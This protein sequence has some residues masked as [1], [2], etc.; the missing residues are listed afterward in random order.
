MNSILKN[1]TIILSIRAFKHYSRSGFTNKNLVKATVDSLDRMG[2]HWI[3]LIDTKNS[4]QK[5][6]IPYL[7]QE[8]CEEFDNL[9]STEKRELDLATHTGF[10]GGRFILDCN[11]QL[12]LATMEWME[13]DDFGENF[14]S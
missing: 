2:V 4:D 10:Y 7:L 6:T 14:E 1:L 5:A 12:D 8:M 11:H 9:P 3:W 13:Q